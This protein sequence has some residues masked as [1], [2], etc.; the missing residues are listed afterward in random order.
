MTPVLELTIRQVTGDPWEALATAR[1]ENELSPPFAVREGLTCKQRVEIRW[2]IEEFM[3]LPEGGNVVRARKVEHELIAYGRQLWN[4]LQGELVTRWLESVRTAGEGRLEL[5]ADTPADEVAFRSPWELLRVGDD[6]SDGVLLQELGVSIVRR[7][8]PTSSARKPRATSAGLRVLAVVCR[9]ADAGFLDP[10]FTPEAILSALESRPEVSVDFCRPGTLDALRDA[11]E[12]AHDEGRP[13]HVVHFDGHGDHGVLLFEDQNGNKDEVEAADLGAELAAFQIPLVVLEACRTAAKASAQDTVAGALLR[14]G[15][16]T[17]IGMG[18][19]VHVDLTRAFTSAFYERVARSGSLGQAM[20]AA[21]THVHLK[22]QRRT[23]IAPEAP[24]VDLHDWFVPQ[25]YQGEFDPVLLPEC[26]H[27]VPRDR[28]QTPPGALH[29][30]PPEPRAGFQGRGYE[31]HRLEREMLRHRIVVIHAPGGMGKTSLAREAAWWWSRIG[32]FPDGAVFVSLEGNPSPDRVVSL[33]GE[34]LEGLDFHKRQNRN[35][36]LTEQLSQRQMLIVWDNFESALPAFSA[37][38]PTPPE[39]HALAQRWTLGRS[40]LLITSRDAKVGLSAHPFALGELTKPEGLLLLISYLDRLG[41]DRASREQHDWTVTDL[42][43]IVTRTDGHPLALELLA[44]FIPRTGPKM[45]MD[46]L[47]ALL[48]QAAQD[49]P[50]GRNRSMWA[51]LEFSIRH[52]SERSRALLPAVALLSG[53]CLETMTQMSLDLDDGDWLEVRHELESSGMVRVEAPFVRPHPV[54][55]EMLQHVGFT[56]TPERKQ[57]FLDIV[58]AFAVEFQRLVHSPQVRLA[59]VI[60]TATET[61]VRRAIELD[62]CAGRLE[63]AAHVSDS[64]QVYLQLTGRA[65]EG[66]IWMTRLQQHLCS[67]DGEIT[68]VAAVTA[69]KVAWSRAAIDPGQAIQDLD[70]VLNR[71]RCAKSWDSRWQQASILQDI[72][73]VHYNFARRPADAIG[74]LKQALWLFVQL[75]SDDESTTIN[76][77]ATLGDLANVFMTLG[78]FPEAMDAAEKSLEFSRARNDLPAIARSEGRIAQI[79]D[80]MGRNGESMVRYDR[81]LA[82][83]EMAGDEE[84]IAITWQSLGSMQNEHNPH[85]AAISFRRAYDAYVRAGDLQGQSQV[86]NSLGQAD[87]RRGDH[88]AAM[89]WYEQSLELSMRLDD[90]EGRARARTNMALLVAEQALQAKDSAERH[91]LL[92]RAIA[93]ERASLN[94][95]QQLGQP[96]SIAASHNNL[97]GHL[98]LAGL[99]DESEQHA[100]HALAIFERLRSANAAKTFHLLERIALTRG[101]LSLAAEYRQSTV[102]AAT[103]ARQ[104]AERPISSQ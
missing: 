48:V 89:A 13:Y 64:L 55:G 93:E 21:R 94:L 10:R 1:F 28:G 73:R 50:E 65:S 78:R 99:L 3:D 79:L 67:A 46:E 61:V 83:A 86:I 44:P 23:R 19:A 88:D 15:I 92:A 25:I 77:A 14:A 102:A 38:Q 35:E 41:H 100:K 101:D 85:E 26:S 80:D 52:L 87:H 60:M 53:G 9:P 17:V 54:L 74:P 30:F 18:H 7:I 6:H 68:E 98:M 43:A 22:R 24:A 104:R 90:M 72:G 69:R 49:S 11:L 5:K 97:A 84:V 82:A 27:Y 47:S 4:S 40:R 45:V 20:Q 58:S 32:M 71:L 29:G 66:I 91:R 70:E 12:Q 75:Q 56:L 16:G 42:E 33:V 37:G 95:E 51:S 76:H 31:L 96:A 81:A 62:L 39:F 34:A 103:E 36:W 57:R 63:H 2:Y 8:D 59:L